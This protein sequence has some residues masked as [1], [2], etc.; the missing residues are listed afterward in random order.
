MFSFT[1]KFEIDNNKSFLCLDIGT[2]FLKVL[3]YKVNLNSIEVVEYLKSRQHSAAMKNGTITSIRRVTE[4]IVQTMANL[5]TKNFAGVIMGIAGELVK[6]VIFEINYDRSDSTK[7]I[8]VDELNTVI[9]KVKNQAY[10]EAQ[11]LIFNQIGEVT[12]E[13][14]NLSLLNYAIVE[15]VLDGFKVEDPVGMT[16]SSAVLKVYFTF[17]P[18]LHVN[19]FKA[20]TDIIKLNLIGIVPQP[21]AVARSING[22]S[23]DDF[24]TIIVDIGGGTTDLALIQNGVPIAT[25]MLAFGSRVFT[26][27]IAVDLNLTLLDAEDFKIR[28][29]RGDL[30]DYRMQEIRNSIINDVSLWVDQL[31]IGLEDFLSLVDGF[32]QTFHLC[33]G[34]SLLPEIKEKLIEYP[35]IR[36]LP[37]N[38]SPK[39]HYIYPSDLNG[40]VD[41]QNLLTSVEDVT[42]ASIARFSL[43]LLYLN[44]KFK[45]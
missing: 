25:N 39:V 26:K 8:T 17:A 31:A 33:G 9:N 3:V 2:E 37:F 45:I 29:S 43:D 38:R 32:P 7:K 14:R 6:G 10:E 35:W 27:R 12:G 28:Y 34:G 41:P 15:S 44:N 19:Y 5:R 40:V 18:V 22:F 42:P 24:S 20:I 13:V 21:F 16:G 4:N 30:S 1:Q 23:K 11:K 36:D